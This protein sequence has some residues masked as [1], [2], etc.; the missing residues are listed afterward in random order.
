M[1]FGIA[2]SLTHPLKRLWPSSDCG[3]KFEPQE[4]GVTFNFFVMKKYLASSLLLLFAVGTNSQTQFSNTTWYAHTNIPVS[5]DIQLVFKNDSLFIL[6]ETGKTIGESMLFLFRNDS[7]YL[8]KISGATPCKTGT[9]GWYKVE[10]P[11]EGDGFI[12]Q[13]IN[14][15]CI[16]RVNFFTRMKLTGKEDDKNKQASGA[17]QSPGRQFYMGAKDFSGGINLYRAYEL[18]KGKK[19]Q[20]VIVGLIGHYDTGHED[21]KGL[22][23]INEKEIPGN[24][25]DDDKNGYADDIHGWNFLSS[26]TGETVPRLQRD[27]TYIYRI[28]K[29][30]YDQADPAKLKP[31]EK[32]EYQIYQKAKKEWA[33]NYEYVPVYKLIR[34]DSAGFFEALKKIADKTSYEGITWTDFIAFD[35]GTDK[36]MQAAHKALQGKFFPERERIIFKNFIQN[37]PRRW[38]GFMN[39]I[40]KFLDFY[41]L[42]YD[43]LKIVGDDPLNMNERNY[44]SP[45][46]KPFTRDMTT[47][48]DTH[49][50]GIIGANRNNGIGMDG[51]ADNVKILCAQSGAGGDERDKDVAN[52]IRY[53]VDNG[54]KVL[55]LSFGKK[56]SSH[57]QAVDD[58]INYAA[59]H[60]VLLVLAAGNDG[61]NCDSVDFYPKARFKNGKLA[62][63]VIRVGCSR[64]KLDAQ[65]PAYYSNYGKQT[66]DLFAPGYD[67]YGPFVNDNYGYAG[68]TSN[69]APFVVGVAALLKSYFP[70]LTMIQVKN[71]ILESVYRPDIKVIR[72]HYI[73]PTLS[74]ARR[75]ALINAGEM[76]PFSSLSRT[77]GIVD[78]EAAVKRAM[79]IAKE[80]T[81]KGF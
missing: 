43:P 45:V 10:W 46:F 78:A 64:T 12:L 19:S 66:V 69:A 48:H 38:Q 54:A 15:P 4:G 36:M 58:A 6:N 13:N 26:K 73:E 71:I 35:P 17:Y 70:E 22:A 34:K 1:E 74:P 72:P 28:W 49:I 24:G 14:D 55:N 42:E 5:A 16:P 60:D 11:Q 30:K 62:S 56:S 50:V 23:W 61:E 2:E 65:L 77:G 40:D 67:S 41:D 32:E 18:L 27:V 59:A 75:E 20:P 39:Y 81:L 21:L 29:H 7:L 57:Q 44:G 31:L 51:I 25:I 80:R 37:F 76:V 47:D 9:A 52:A 53:A 68:G 33:D 8:E 63:N 79:E 3:F